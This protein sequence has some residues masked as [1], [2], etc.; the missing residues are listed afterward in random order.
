MSQ[1]KGHMAATATWC[2]CFSM[3]AELEG[4]RWKGGGGLFHAKTTTRTI[5]T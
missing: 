4:I 3:C 1:R 5:R 2:N